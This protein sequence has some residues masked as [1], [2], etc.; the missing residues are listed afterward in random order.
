MEKIPLEVRTEGLYCTAGNFYIDAYQPVETCVVTHAHGDHAYRGHQRYIVTEDTADLLEYRLGK[1]LPFLR[2]PY[3]QPLKLDQCWISLH[4]AGHILGSAQVRIE[5]KEGVFVVSGD[6]KR[7]HDS[8]CL[9]FEVIPCDLFI[10]ENTFGL[11]LFKWED[12]EVTAEKIAAWWNSNK[13]FDRPSVL[14]CYALG[15]AQRILSLLKSHTNQPIYLHGAIQPL[16]EIYF[17]KGVPMAPFLPVSSKPKEESFSKDLI[18]APPSA[19]GT[20]WLKRFPHFRTAAASGWMQ[21]RGTR[22]RKGMD[23]GFVLS[24]HADWGSLLETIEATG[25][26]TVLMTH[27]YSTPLSR[28]LREK[29]GIE[30]YELRGL[31]IRESEEE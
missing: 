19:A 26:K 9:P 12:S 28:Y 24:D 30:A 25:A 3:N 14:F 29:Q 6:Y 27:G 31:E 7:A 22:K 2:L 4:P 15:K 5:T 13:I 11:P 1:D 16:T 17:R 10:T 8:T 20:P 18:L 23:A 21:V